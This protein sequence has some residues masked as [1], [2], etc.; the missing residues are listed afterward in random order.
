MKTSKVHSPDIPLATSLS[1]HLSRSILLATS[2]SRHPR[3][4]ARF[5]PVCG[6][7]PKLSV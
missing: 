4:P 1:Q 7:P 6:A 3:R 2:L 5:T